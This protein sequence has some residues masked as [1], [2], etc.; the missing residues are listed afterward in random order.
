MLHKE[1]LWATGS[2]SS[3]QTWKDWGNGLAWAYNHLVVVGRGDAGILGWSALW[4]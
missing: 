1:T 4:D 3:D 2:L